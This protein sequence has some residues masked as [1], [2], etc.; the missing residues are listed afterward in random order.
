MCDIIKMYRDQG[1]TCTDC[2]DCPY[3]YDCFIAQQEEE[4]EES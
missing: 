2:H 1:A 4:A 3:R